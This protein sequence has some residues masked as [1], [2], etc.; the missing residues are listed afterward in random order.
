MFIK[1]CILYTKGIFDWEA[2]LFVVPKYMYIFIQMLDNVN[3]N[4]LAAKLM[5]LN[6]VSFPLCT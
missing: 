2:N 3:A 5:K 4:R 6:A 1:I